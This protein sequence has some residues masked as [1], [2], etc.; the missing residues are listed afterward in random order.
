MTP[1]PN[2]LDELSELLQAFASGRDR[3]TDLVRQMDEQL[4]RDFPNG[5]GFPDAEAFAELETAT[6]CFKPGGG[7]FMYDEA[8]MALVCRYV[9][10]RL[11]KTNV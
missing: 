11:G 1:P 8:Q 7:Q 3:S 4:S 9:L 5:E 6:A 2:A 10:A